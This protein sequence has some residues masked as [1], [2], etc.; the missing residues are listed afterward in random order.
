MS[1]K[2]IKLWVDEILRG[3]GVLDTLTT[4]EF[5]AFVKYC[6][7]A[8]KSPHEVELGKIAM[9]NDVNFTSDQITKLLRIEPQ[10]HQIYLDKLQKHQMLTRNGDVI[11]ISNFAKFNPDW[12]RI[13][14]YQSQ[15]KTTCRFPTNIKPTGEI[16]KDKNKNKDKININNINSEIKDVYQF[17]LIALPVK[18]RDTEFIDKEKLDLIKKR[19]ERFKADEIKLAII[20]LRQ[21]KYLM[22]QNDQRKI[23]L[24]FD[25]IFK[26]KD[27][28]LSEALDRA[29]LSLKI[30]GLSPDD[31]S[32]VIKEDI[33]AFI[34]KTH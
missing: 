12:E 21:D 22:G 11:F 1:R 10:K 7:L 25:Y 29:Y 8:G 15:R 31:Q 28:K 19:L 26:R 23:Y 27:E 33:D 34:A 20:E 4:E 2:W 24:T 14:D 32:K 16:R 13:K 9:S 30:N 5:G 3:G 6:V 18:P 17:C